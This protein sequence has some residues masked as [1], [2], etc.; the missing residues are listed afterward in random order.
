MYC[1]VSSSNW[2]EGYVSQD[3]EVV[4]A[5]D[6]WLSLHCEFPYILF[7]LGEPGRA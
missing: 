5:N 1:I 6:D 3:P 4:Q 7:V 2:G